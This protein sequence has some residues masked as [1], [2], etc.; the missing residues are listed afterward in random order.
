MY[1]LINESGLNI[2]HHYRLVRGGARFGR[3]GASSGAARALGGG[4]TGEAAA[5][6]AARAPA[7]AARPP[8]RCELQ[9]ARPRAR[10]RQTVV[11]KGVARFLFWNLFA[12]GAKIHTVKC[13]LCLPIYA[14]RGLPCVAHG[15]H[16]AV[17]IPTFAVFP[18]HTANNWNHVVHIATSA[19]WPI[20]CLKD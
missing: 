19:S 14:V 1:T 17:C 9:A 16:F 15:K 20:G 7:V 13:S 6:G 12:V 18:W 10:R 8:A 3:G 4:A 5:D 2:L 11:A